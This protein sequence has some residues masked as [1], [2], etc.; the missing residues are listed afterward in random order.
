M[1]DQ[2]SNF[3]STMR[4]SLTYILL[5]LQEWFARRAGIEAWY[6]CIVTRTQTIHG[7]LSVSLFH[8]GQGSALWTHSVL[9]KLNA[10]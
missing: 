10:G 4:Q 6:K 9:R 3:D 7:D 8:S 5:S 1:R 2:H